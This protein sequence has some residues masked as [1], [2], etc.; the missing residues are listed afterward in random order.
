MN[1][2][3][4]FE[5]R[6]VDVFA[7]R[8][9]RGNGLT[10]FE[11]HQPVPTA[12]LQRITQEMRQFESIF[13]WSTG[14][15]NRWRAR[16]FTMEEELAFAGHPVIGAACVLHERHAPAQDEFSLVLA[17]P[18]KQVTVT[19]R[20]SA[21]DY[22]AE[23]DQ[24]VAEFVSTVS[25][26]AQA[27]LLAA[28]N[29]QPA[30]LAPGLPLQVVST[31]LP[32][33]IV[34]LRAGLE[35]MRISHRH[36]E[37]LLRPWGAKFAYAIDLDTLEGRTWDND[38]RVEDIATGSAA[39]PAAA[40]LAR[41]GIIPT[42]RPVVLHQGRFLGRPSEL[43]VRVSGDTTL[44]VSVSGAVAFVGAGFLDLPAADLQ[45]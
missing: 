33:L 37:A 12:L 9:L 36:F 19:S 17:L 15:A 7:A 24:G 32:Y 27:E 34:P 45:A 3:V 18:D 30:D 14:Q 35:R 2:T 31:G 5:Y 11:L 20:R 40:W 26:G 44:S 25:T 4:R 13:L 21:V 22:R 28:M 23:M 41:H 10:A 43:Q 6:H 38:G 29:L 1:T 16:M 39:G 8:P 42:G